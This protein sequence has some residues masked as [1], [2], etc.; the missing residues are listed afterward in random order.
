[1][2]SYLTPISHKKAPP[3]DHQ[4]GQSSNGFRIIVGSSLPLTDWLLHCKVR[5][6]PE[7]MY[8]II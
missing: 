8:Y 2:W 3:G 5:A 4:A 6:A 7:K 1:V